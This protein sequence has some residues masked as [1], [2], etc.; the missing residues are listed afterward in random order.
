[1]GRTP[2]PGPETWPR[3]LCPRR[4][5]PGARPQALPRHV[6]AAS[7]GGHGGG[8]GYLASRFC[9]RNPHWCR[10]RWSISR[11]VSFIACGLCAVRQAPLP[12]PGALF[13]DASGAQS[14]RG[15]GKIKNRKKKPRTRSPSPHIRKAAP[16]YFSGTQPRTSFERTR[17]G[18]LP[19]CARCLGACA[20]ASVRRGIRA[21][22]TLPRCVRAG[23]A[24]SRDASGGL[25]RR[26]TEGQDPCRRA[27]FAAAQARRPQRAAAVANVVAGISPAA[28][29]CA[30]DASGPRA[31]FCLR[32]VRALPR[33]V[34]ST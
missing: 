19:F 22:A 11:G 27:E 28:G 33:A 5:R 2:W 3:R 30:A 31:R 24:R 29:R 12:P 32:R 15:R 18:I 13:P 10:T 14:L 25:P 17:H 20:H 16:T 9:A 34:C 23:R 7:R 26:A 8:G 4:A 21:T 1:V 6:P